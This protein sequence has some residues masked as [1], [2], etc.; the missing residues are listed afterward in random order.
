MTN[1]IFI[2]CLDS[3]PSDPILY[4]R[5][6]CLPGAVRATEKLPVSFGAVA[7][8]FAPAMITNR[9]KFMDRAFKTIESMMI[10]RC[11]HFERQVI[12]VATDFTLCH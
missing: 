1:S 2:I 7:D 10:T 12:L 9:R 6:T 3:L 8:N 5:Y 11:Y 4:L